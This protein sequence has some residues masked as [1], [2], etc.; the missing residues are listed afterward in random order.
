MG[1]TWSWFL[2][3]NIMTLCLAESAVYSDL[4]ITMLAVSSDLCVR[5]SACLFMVVTVLL[6]KERSLQCQKLLLVMGSQ[7]YT[8]IYILH[9][10][11]ISYY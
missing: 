5:V 9:I 6:Q 1:D 4:H 3:C 10:G 11:L 7:S 8:V 2:V